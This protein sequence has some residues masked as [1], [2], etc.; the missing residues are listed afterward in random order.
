MVMVSKHI[1]KTTVLMLKLLGVVGIL[2]FPMVDI[3]QKI[4][5]VYKWNGLVIETMPISGLIIGTNLKE[6]E[7]LGI[8]RCMIKIEDI[9]I[10]RK[11]ISFLQSKQNHQCMLNFS[12]QGMAGCGE[13]VQH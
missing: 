10:M 6:V 5:V 3:L 8:T 11:E 4:L 9:L 2:Q 12:L 7:Q 1:L 13:R